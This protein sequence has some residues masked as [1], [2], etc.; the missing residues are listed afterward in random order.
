MHEVLKKYFMQCQAPHAY[1]TRAA[2]FFLFRVH[3]QS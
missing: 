3:S 2:L 1:L